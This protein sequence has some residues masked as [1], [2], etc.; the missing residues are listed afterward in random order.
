MKV[1]ITGVAGFIGSHLADY[2]I[3]THGWDVIGIDNFLTGSSENINPKVN[4]YSSDLRVAEDLDELFRGVDYVFHL[5]AIARTPWTI[6][7]PVLAVQTNIVG[8]TR[9]LEGA[10]KA[11]VKKV[12]FASSNIIYAEHTPYYVT[13]LAGEKMMR[14]YNELHG[15]PTISLR[16]SNVYGSRRQSEKGPSINVLAALAK[17]K[18]ERGYIHIT[19]DGEQSRD[20]THVLDIVEGIYLAAVKAVSG[21]EIDLCT[22][23]NIT[24]NQVAKMFDCPVV[25]VADRLGDE[26]HINQTTGKAKELLGFEA[27]RRLEDNIDIYL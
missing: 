19:G 17:S 2:L 8:T 16:F 10:R 6:E 7:D 23:R 11:G 12:I 13:K 5:A 27:K 4:F 9:V 26:K 25:Y 20:F 24:M 3:D 1:L 15:L 21:D 22:G 14:V 18:R